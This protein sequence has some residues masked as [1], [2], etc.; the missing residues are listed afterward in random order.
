MLLKKESNSKRKSWL[1]TIIGSLSILIGFSIPI[2]KFLIDRQER[3]VEKSLLEDFYE[4]QKQETPINQQEQEDTSILPTE[5]KEVKHQNQSKYV[6]VIKIPKINLERGLVAKDS[7]A[8]NVNKNIKI[9]DES[10]NPET[11]KGNVILAAHSGNAKMSYFRYL[12]KLVLNDTITII[13]NGHEYIYEVTNIYDI[14]K[15]G[16]ADIV[17]DLNKKT[18]TLITCRQGTNKQIVI[19]CELKEERSLS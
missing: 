19:V 4:E 5:K 1:F 12:Y 10:D 9:L 3:E 7:S 14:N 18:L 16:E 11:P 2:Y 17:R 6:A 15:T 13:F 8:N